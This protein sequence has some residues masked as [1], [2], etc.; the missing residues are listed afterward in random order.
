MRDSSPNLLHPPSDGM[1]V[2]V[3]TSITDVVPNTT[4]QVAEV[5]E[6]PTSMPSS[7]I[8]GSRFYG[9]IPKQGNPEPVVIVDNED[10]GEDQQQEAEVD[11]MLA[12]TQ[13]STRDLPAQTY[14]FTLD[15]LGTRHPQ[16]IKVLRQYLKRE[17][18]DKFNFDEVRVA[19]SKQVQVP[20]Q[21]NTWDCG[22]YLL[23]FVKVLMSARSEFVEQI[24]S[25]KGTMPSSERK[26]MWQDHEVPQ[27]R[28]HLKSR[29]IQLSEEWKAEK[30][31]REDDANKRSG[32][33]V[34]VETLSSEGEVD[35]VED[36]PTVKATRGPKQRQ[37]ATRLRG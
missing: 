18:K 14:I 22:I 23:H 30:T 19:A 13:T 4:L 6:P 21:P 26:K 8:P 29:I 9:S 10:S 27:F 31:V 36:I 7:G 25:T 35:I 15:S 17:A 32:D 11:D 12:V 16:A 3:N 24:L 2:D 37:H 34:E 20:V 28:D 5:Q 33:P 1:E